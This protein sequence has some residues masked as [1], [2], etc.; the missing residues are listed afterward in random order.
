MHT[1]LLTFSVSHFSEKA[2]W[3][4]DANG[5]PYRE[6]PLPLGLHVPYVRWRAPRSSV[7]VL[8]H[9]G[10]VVQGSSAILDFLERRLGGVA[11]AAPEQQR[12]RAA[13]LEALADR[14]FGGGIVRVLYDA[15]LASPDDMVP[16]W[17]PDL[18]DGAPVATQR[19]LYRAAFPWL[20]W[21]IR[22]TYRIRPD[23]VRAA[24]ERLI[25]GFDETDRALGGRPYLL[26][27]RPTRV[28]VT[29]AALL[30]P[31]CRPREHMLTWPREFPPALTELVAVLDR[32][33]TWELVLRMY[34]EHRATRPRAEA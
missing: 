34:R 13:E 31:L 26:G 14:A 18:H 1:R 20:R 15:L 27:P 21:G 8:E 5:V 3:A 33:P 12:A 9:G 17:A 11:L 16:L 19:R 25:A 2:R 4:L 30:A 10:D 28:D 24:R 29:V 22:R 32:R 6:R 7:P 23:T